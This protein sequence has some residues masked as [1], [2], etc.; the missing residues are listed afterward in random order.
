MY[1]PLGYPCARS[2]RRLGIGV[3]VHP[4]TCHRLYL[5]SE[6]TSGGHWHGDL[7]ELHWFVLH[8]F[9]GHSAFTSMSGGLVYSV[10][11][12]QLLSQVGFGWTTRIMG[13][14]ALGTLSTS[15]VV[16]RRRVTTRTR[17]KLFEAQAWKELPYALFC[18]GARW[19]NQ[20]KA[21]TR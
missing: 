5:L 11:F 7:R 10:I 17:R 15:L 1:I 14:I 12:R 21:Q 13:F 3:P 9:H 2:L 6:E 8:R 20:L 19:F 4:W 16:M 18:I